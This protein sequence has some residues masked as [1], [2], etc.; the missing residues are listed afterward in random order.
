MKNYFYILP[1]LLG[2]GYLL[3]NNKKKL[4]SVFPAFE[5]EEPEI[6]AL[7]LD[8]YN[9]FFDAVETVTVMEG[10][11]VPVSM[12]LSV[13]TKESGQLYKTKQNKDVI[14]D[15]GTA[16]GYMQVRQPALTDVNNR[17]NKFYKF[18]DLYDEQVNLIVGC[19][20]LDLCYK[21]AMQNKSI[22]PV[23]LAFK[24]YNGGI[25]E[26]DLSFNVLAQVYAERTYYYYHKF[27]WLTK[28][29]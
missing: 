24:K 16:I 5:F 22:N 19:S 29:F 6:E 10:L 1:L 4:M 17:Y 20:Y 25:D 11:S 21:S 3:V 2:A 26:T 14:G 27:D 7:Y 12:C 18:T 9:R 23:K 13:L 8:I 28:G 15:N